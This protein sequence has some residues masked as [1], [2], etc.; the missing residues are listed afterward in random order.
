MVS[1]AVTA[2]MTGAVCVTGAPV[3]G[4]M[5][6]ALPLARERHASRCALHVM[7]T[8]AAICARARP[9]ERVGNLLVHHEH[10]ALWSLAWEAAFEV[11]PANRAPSLEDCMKGVNAA[12]DTLAEYHAT[13]LEGAPPGLKLQILQGVPAYAPGDMADA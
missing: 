11:L 1:S 10:D 5:T 3:G 13:L 6:D 9:S 8:T 4:P 7:M 12:L 2:P